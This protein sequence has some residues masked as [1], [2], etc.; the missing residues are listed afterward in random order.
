MWRDEDYE[1][2]S[3]LDEVTEKRG[4]SAAQIGSLEAETFDECVQTKKR[5][6]RAASLLK[7]ST[8]SLPTPTHPLVN[9]VNMPVPAPVTSPEAVFN[10]FEEEAA[11]A[12]DGAEEDAA[13]PPSRCAICL[14]PFASQDSVKCLPCTHVYHGD[15]IDQWL[16]RKPNCP[17]CKREIF[18]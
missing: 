13:K 1:L 10:A 12:D 2:L 18:S 3:T 11:S 15:C 14:E 8:Q 7:V 4:A 6:S 9:S 5:R 16:T 17:V